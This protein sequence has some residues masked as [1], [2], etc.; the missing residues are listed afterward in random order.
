MGGVVSYVA[1]VIVQVAAAPRGCDKTGGVIARP[2]T[3]RVWY[4]GGVD[5]QQQRRTRGR[6]RLCRR[7]ALD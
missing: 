5:Q 4:C 3:H 6:S 7:S 1:P 2:T